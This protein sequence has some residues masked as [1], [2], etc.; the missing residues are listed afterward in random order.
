MAS[1]AGCAPFWA[2]ADPKVSSLQITAVVAA[3]AQRVAGTIR[4]SPSI[5]G[6][7]RAT[8][9][10]LEAIAAKGDDWFALELAFAVQLLD[11]VHDQR[12][13]AAGLLTRLGE[14]IPADGL[15][16]VTGGIEGETMRPLD[17]APFPDRPA[18]GC[19]SRRRS[20]PTSSAWRAGRRTT[21]AGAWTSRTTR[22]PR[23]SSGAAT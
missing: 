19:S 18:R 5:R 9:Y 10:C 20:A 4:P 23:S 2:N 3:I 11:S 6:S 7:A 1:A 13:E 21:A 17:F 14:R 8:D 22:P 16:P 15:V 12:P